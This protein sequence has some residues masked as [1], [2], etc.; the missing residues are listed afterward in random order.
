MAQ[1]SA[2]LDGRDVFDTLLEVSADV[3]NLV[4]TVTDSPTEISGHLLNAPRSLSAY[5][6]IAF[7]AERQLPNS[8][9]RRVVAG[10]L[11]SSGGF[12]LASLPAGKYLLAV[13]EDAEQGSWYDP[14]LLE[15]L[16]PTAIPVTVTDGQKVVQDLRV[17]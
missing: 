5:T 13:L 9:A 15:A 17:R 8:L 11:L 14:K 1:K 4:I 16:R 12:V 6:V 7:P 3:D 2:M 10:T